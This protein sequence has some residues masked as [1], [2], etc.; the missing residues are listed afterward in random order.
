[1]YKFVLLITLLLAGV[2]PQV[3]CG[4]SVTDQTPVEV[5]PV[6][7]YEEHARAI[8]REWEPDAFL[9]SVAVKPLSKN[10]NPRGQ[11]PDRLSFQFVAPNNTWE[12][13][14]VTFA[15]DGTPEISRWP[16]ADSPNEYIPIQQSDWTLDSTDAWRIALEEIQET[17]TRPNEINATMHLERWNPPR[18][19]QV[20][21]YVGNRS[22]APGVSLRIWIDPKTGEIVDRKSP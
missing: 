8:A 12:S 2:L 14:A 13:L 7:E 4:E 5:R 18:S 15:L 19:G 11:T 10:L 21:W 20:L 9:F 17:T 1:M 22:S 16:L 6:K 3:S